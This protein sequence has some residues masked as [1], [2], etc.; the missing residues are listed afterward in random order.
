MPAPLTDKQAK[1]LRF[2]E[3]Q[4]DAGKSAPTCC[5]VRE[6]TRSDSS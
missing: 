4:M 5:E 3:E 6:E 2:V 1:I